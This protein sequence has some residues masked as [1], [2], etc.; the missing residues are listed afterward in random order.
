MPAVGFL[1]TL[2][3]CSA[4]SSLMS[5][6][7]W[8]TPQFPGCFPRYL[9]LFQCLPHACC[10]LNVFTQANPTW[11]KLSC[12]QWNLDK[13]TCGKETNTHKAGWLSG[14]L[15][16][17]PFQFFSLELILFEHNSAPSVNA[18]LLILLLYRKQIIMHDIGNGLLGW[19]R[20]DQEN[21]LITSNYIWYTCTTLFLK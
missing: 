3:L 7:C 21:T 4:A 20:E 17:C 13:N 18:K 8:S 12:L 10:S 9:D 6:V 2:R 11:K 1:H 14:T 15:I 16:C 19:H 5:C